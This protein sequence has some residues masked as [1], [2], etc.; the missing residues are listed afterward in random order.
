MTQTRPAPGRSEE[1]MKERETEKLSPTSYHT[2]SKSAHYHVASMHDSTVRIESDDILSAVFH[3]FD[4]KQTLQFRVTSSTMVCLAKCIKL[5][6]AA[7][8]VET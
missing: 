8:K 4:G 7:Q 5:W 6:E 1:R 2:G 3:I